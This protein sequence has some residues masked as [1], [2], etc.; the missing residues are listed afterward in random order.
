M[1][2]Q[3]PAIGVTL[4]FSAI[5]VLGDYFL[6]LASAENNPWANRWFALGYVVYS[7]TAF[8][9]V[10]VMKHLKLAT[11]GVVYSVAMIVLLTLV[12]S[13][14]FAE[15]LTAYEVGGILMGLGALAL[16]ARFA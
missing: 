4:L 9:W 6:K 3:L 2:E 5:G 15:R 1:T 12:G 7:T 10:Y 16:L 11:I 14:F 13:L 8:G